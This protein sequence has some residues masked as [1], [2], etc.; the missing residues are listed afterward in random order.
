MGLQSEGWV[1]VG[2][3]ISNNK[4]PSWSGFRESGM[5]RGLDAK[6]MYELVKTK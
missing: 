3:Q 2:V 4:S 5:K 1:G 6:I